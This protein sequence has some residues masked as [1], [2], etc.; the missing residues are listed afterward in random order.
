MADDDDKSETNLLQEHLEPEESI[1][2]LP[3]K[4]K[5]ATQSALKQNKSLANQPSKVLAFAAPST[6]PV[7]PPAPVTSFGKVASQFGSFFK[8]KSAV[9]TNSDIVPQA[10]QASHGASL[11]ERRSP[12]SH[13]PPRAEERR[14]RVARPRS[15]RDYVLN[16]R[17]DLADFQETHGLPRTRDYSFL[18]LTL[19]LAQETGRALYAVFIMIT[20]LFPVLA[21][22]SLILRFTLDK[23]LEILETEDSVVQVKKITIFIIQLIA[24]I[25]PVYI[26]I[27]TIIA[28]LIYL[29]FSIFKKLFRLT[30]G[31]GKAKRIPASTSAC[32]SC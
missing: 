19:A 14:E 6:D 30:A 2:A 10:P 11:F 28:P 22:L 15:V 8:S 9:N 25:I 1:P 3:S 13:N 12:F 18:S 7:E 31:R 26:T 24:I 23:L 20:E 5:S 21:I 27:G 29:V 4:S 32:P 17:E 16:F